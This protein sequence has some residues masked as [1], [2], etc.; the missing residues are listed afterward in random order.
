M[1]K[2]LSVVKDCQTTEV[3]GRRL[4]RLPLQWFCVP[5]LLPGPIHG[6]LQNLPQAFW[7]L[8]PHANRVRKLS[9]NISKR[10]PGLGAHSLCS[11]CPVMCMQ[12]HR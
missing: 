1:P 8:R 4:N 12:E 9:E 2:S 5:Q 6:P 3:A 11:I 7:P 10:E